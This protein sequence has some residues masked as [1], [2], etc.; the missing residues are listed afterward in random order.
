MKFSIAVF[1][2]FTV[3]M[4]EL[5]KV[6]RQANVQNAVMTD[7]NGAVVAFNAAGVVKDNGN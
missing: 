5:R 4:A 2:L 1:A 7:A 3:A 6:P